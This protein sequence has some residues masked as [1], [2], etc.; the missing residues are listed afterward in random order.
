MVSWRLTK[1][2]VVLLGHPDERGPP[3]EL[4]E[5]GSPDIGTGRPQSSKDVQNRVLY[6]PFVRHL[7]SLALRGPGEGGEG[8][9]RLIQFVLP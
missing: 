2:R 4:F 7:H 3:A 8:G 1:H 6:I 9:E 5:L